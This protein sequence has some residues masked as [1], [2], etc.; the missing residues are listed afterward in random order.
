VAV[1]VAVPVEVNVGGIGVLVPVQVA[2]PVVDAVG[3][4]VFVGNPWVGVQ[5]LVLVGVE[6]AVKVFVAV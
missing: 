3:V 4:L 2:V 1:L 6:V 5:E